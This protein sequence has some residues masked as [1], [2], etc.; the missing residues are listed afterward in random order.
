M[1]QQTTPEHSGETISIFK[2]RPRDERGIAVTLPAQRTDGR[3]EDRHTAY[4]DNLSPPV[5]WREVEGAQYYALI[6]EDPDAPREQPFVHWM[7]W[8]IPGALTRLDEGLP[9]DPALVTP[10]SAI[11]G[12]NDMGG[13][14]W[15][16]PRPPRGHG[17]HHYY[18]QLFALDGPLEMG[19]DT[20]LIELLNALK[21]HTIAEGEAMATYDAPELS[22]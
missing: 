7:I 1:P 8:D 4:H 9:N 6:V 15:F 18:F 5:E 20:P 2:V 11:Q 16:G 12:K 14:G 19:P 3:F 10:Q 21:A 13:Y 22:S 17:V